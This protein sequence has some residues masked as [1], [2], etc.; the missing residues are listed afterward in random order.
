MV[1]GATALILVRSTF[2]GLALDRMGLWGPSLP[3]LIIPVA[4]PTTCDR[5]SHQTGTIVPQ[6]GAPYGVHHRGTG[7]HRGTPTRRGPHAHKASQGPQG[8]G[9]FVARQPPPCSGHRDR[10]AHQGPG[11]G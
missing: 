9:Y 8:L 4:N 6:G 5:K 3:L 2:V 10:G 1:I 7:L 11:V